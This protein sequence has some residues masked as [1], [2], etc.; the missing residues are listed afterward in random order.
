MNPP[1]PDSQARSVNHGVV[2]STKLGAAGAPSERDLL[3][4]SATF[5]FVERVI[6]LIA[7]LASL[8]GLSRLCAVPVLAW[9]EETQRGDND[10]RHV[11]FLTFTILVNAQL[12]PSLNIEKLLSSATIYRK[13]RVGDIESARAR[14]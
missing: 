2:R 8:R 9:A 7:G 1:W 6:R 11:A 14:V 3:L 4:F 5:S 13:E 10:F 12:E